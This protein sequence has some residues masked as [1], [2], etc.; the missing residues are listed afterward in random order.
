MPSPHRRSESGQAS[1]DY[2]ALIALVAVVLT[3]AA[4]AVGGAQ[5]VSAVTG[6]VRVAVCIV[7]GDICRSSDARAKGLEPCVVSGSEKGR[8]TSMTMVVGAERGRVVTIQRRSDHTAVLMAGETGEGQLTLRS[9][10]RVGRANVGFEAGMGLTWKQGRAWEFADEAALQAF[11]RRFPHP[12]AL[13]DDLG[14]GVLKAPPPDWRYRESGTTRGLRVG[15][16]AGLDQSVARAARRRAL[17]RRERADGSTTW[18]FDA[19]DEGVRLLGGLLKEIRLSEDSAIRL[20]ATTDAAGVPRDARYRITGAGA[21]DG[22]IV[23][24]IAPLDLRSPANAAA[25]RELITRAPAGTIGLARAGALLRRTLDRDRLERRVYR[26]SEGT[27]GGG[28]KVFGV[29][30]DHRTSASLR[31]LVEAQAIDADGRTSLRADCLPQA[32]RDPR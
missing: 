19:T 13:A 11:L 17:G 12:E 4:V 24:L 28:L 22:E 1:A 30:V 18:Y 23:E 26:E 3:G 10:A 6:V 14:A 25:A 32:D 8:S 5:I 31:T 20:E 29:G 9:G 27:R 7:G 16:E 21:R 2:V 15:A